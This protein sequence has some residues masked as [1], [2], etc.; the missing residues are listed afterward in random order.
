MVLRFS[1][2]DLTKHPVLQFVQGEAIKNS[3]SLTSLEWNNKFIIPGEYDI[4]ILFDNNNNGKWDPGDY[5]KKLQPERAITLKEKLGVRANW[6]N[7]RD[8]KL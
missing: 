4:R 2:L 5:S 7:E 1:N 3:Y 8:I 6:D